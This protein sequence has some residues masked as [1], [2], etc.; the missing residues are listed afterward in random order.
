MQN[1]MQNAAEWP[2]SISQPPVF[3]SA[4]DDSSSGA[5]GESCIHT[6]AQLQIH[7]STLNA[8]VT[9]TIAAVAATIFRFAWPRTGQ[10]FHTLFIR[11]WACRADGMRQVRGW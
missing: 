8:N 10:P 6:A 3:T 5:C 7:G 9:C 2:L 4:C 11:L 1:V